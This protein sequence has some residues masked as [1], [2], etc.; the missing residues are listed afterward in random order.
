[1]P[2]R[3]TSRRGT[4]DVKTLLTEKTPEGTIFIPFHFREAAA[5]I[6]TNPATDPEAGIPEFK[7]CAVKVAPLIQ[8]ERPSEKE[9]QVLQH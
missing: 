4:L 7:V 3:V 1:M 5:N 2:V 8:E 6:L 9:E